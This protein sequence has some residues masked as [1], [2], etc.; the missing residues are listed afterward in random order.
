MNS[1]MHVEEQWLL[2]KRALK[3]VLDNSF[4][5]SERRNAE[6]VLLRAATS[7]L[8]LYMSGDNDVNK[9]VNVLGLI[10]PLNITSSSGESSQ[11]DIHEEENNDRNSEENQNIPVNPTGSMNFQDLGELFNA[12]TNHFANLPAQFQSGSLDGEELRR[13]FSFWPFTEQEN[14]NT[15]STS[16]SGQNTNTN[17]GQSPTSEQVN[18]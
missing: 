2:L 13:I 15:N 10:P 18:R 3:K 11:Q 7:S 16:T 12:T 8:D 1:N 6:A 14:S 9:A 17:S 4:E 5:S